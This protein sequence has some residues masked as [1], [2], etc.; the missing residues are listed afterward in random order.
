MA[1]SE[2][3]TL[4]NSSYLSGID[5]MVS[6]LDRFISSQD[7]AA[8]ATSRAVDSQISS[9]ER[10]TKRPQSRHNRPCSLN[11]CHRPR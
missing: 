3:S 9:L 7:T 1:L 5:G 4:D 11:R 6:G 10:S 2:T 8:A